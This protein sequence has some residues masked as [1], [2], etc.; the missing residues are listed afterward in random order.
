MPNPYR[1]NPKFTQ[2]NHLARYIVTDMCKAE[3]LPHVTKDRQAKQL[4]EYSPKN[5]FVVLNATCTL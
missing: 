1:L 3:N 2:F 5:W 4:R